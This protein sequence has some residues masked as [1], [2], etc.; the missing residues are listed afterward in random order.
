MFF[1]VREIFYE[2]F[3]YRSHL[4]YFLST[5]YLTESLLFRFISI[6]T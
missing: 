6:L 1:F 5:V 4:Y 2:F 3:M